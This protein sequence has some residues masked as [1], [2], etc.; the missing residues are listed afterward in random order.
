M[1]SILDPEAD[2]V[3]QFG[4]CFMLCDTKKT[5]TSRDWGKLDGVHL[6]SEL[7]VSQ[8]PCI[9]GVIFYEEIAI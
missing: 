2:F 6:T 1:R 7:Q 9:K 4:T 5:P 8:N 3:S